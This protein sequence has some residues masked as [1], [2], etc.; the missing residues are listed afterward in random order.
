MMPL[1]LIWEMAPRESPHIRFV[2]SLGVYP[3]FCD[4]G[5][6]CLARTLTFRQLTTNGFFHAKPL[7]VKNFYQGSRVRNRGDTKKHLPLYLA[8]SSLGRPFC[9]RAGSISHSPYRGVPGLAPALLQQ[10]VLTENQRG[11]QLV[12]LNSGRQLLEARCYAH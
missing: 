11:E 6:F 12:H 4:F 10:L 5:A 1:S 8:A 3:H 2:G 9:R 7:K